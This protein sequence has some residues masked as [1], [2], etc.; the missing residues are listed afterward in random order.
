MIRTFENKDRKI[1]FFGAHHSKN[2]E[3]IEEIKRIISNFKPEIILIEDQF[4]QFTYPNEEAAIEN[5]AEMGFACFFAKEKGIK[6]ISNDP[7]RTEEYKYMENKYGR[8]KVFIYYILRPLE[9]MK[10]QQPEIYKNIIVDLIQNFKSEANW[11]DFDFSQKSF[12]KIFEKIFLCPYDSN[13]SF[14]DYFN[15]TLD[16]NLLNEMT[17]DLN[18]FRDDFMISILKEILKKFNR[19]FI[20]KG[21]HH[22]EKYKNKI[23]SILECQEY[24]R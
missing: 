7:P 5:G 4:H 22:L 11:E 16:L 6:V 3:Q 17:R 19:I 1:V 8:E 10:K 2:K 13:K 9:Q 12:N 20:I 23:K 18:M 15:P 24:L 14:Y 21:H